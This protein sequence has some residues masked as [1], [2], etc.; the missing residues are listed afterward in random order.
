MGKSY[1]TKLTLRGVEDELRLRLEFAGPE[2]HAQMVSAVALAEH[3]GT[4]TVVQN[5]RNQTVGKVIRGTRLSTGVSFSEDKSASHH[6]LRYLFEMY[7]HHSADELHETVSSLV[8]RKANRSRSIALGRLVKPVAELIT[9]S[10]QPMP[11]TFGTARGIFG[12][13][14]DGLSHVLVL[15]IDK[16]PPLKHVDP[17]IENWPELAQAIARD[18]LPE[19]EFGDAHVGVYATSKFG[20]V[21]AN[22]ISARVVAWLKTALTLEQQAFW[23]EEVLRPKIRSNV[24]EWA[25]EAPFDITIYHPS[26]LIYTALPTIIVNDVEQPDPFPQRYIVFKG[27]GDGSVENDSVPLEKAQR[28]RSRTVRKKIEA[29]EASRMGV[30]QR[31]IA[32][33]SFETPSDGR[34]N[35]G[36]LIE[37]LIPGDTQR[38]LT[39]AIARAATTTPKH[40]TAERRNALREEIEIAL[41]RMPDDAING[42]QRRAEWVYPLEA[43]WERAEQKLKYCWVSQVASRA[44]RKR[45]SLEDGRALV[46]Q[47]IS[48][49]VDN[50]LAWQPDDTKVFAVAPHILINASLG[51]GKTEALARALKDI[52]LET[53][54]VHVLVP[55]DKLGAEVTRRI[56]RARHEREMRHEDRYIRQHRGR[57]QPGMC[58]NEAFGRHCEAMEEMGFSPYDEVCRQMCPDAKK[59]PWAQQHHDKGTGVIVRTHAHI[60]STY[61]RMG[62]DSD[63]KPDLFVVDE[64]P[65]GAVKTM[66]PDVPLADIK[67]TGRYAMQKYFYKTDGGKRASRISISGTADFAAHRN[68]LLAVLSKQD[69]VVR[70]ADFK[71][72]SNYVED[73]ESEYRFA[74]SLEHKLRT[75]INFELKTHMS[76]VREAGGRLTNEQ[77]ALVA[78]MQKQRRTSLAVTRLLMAA[79]ISLENGKL[80]RVAGVRIRDVKGDKVLS[81]VYSDGLP[82]VFRVTPTIFLD[83]TSHPLIASAMSGEWRQVETI[84]VHIE[85]GAYWYTYVGDQAHSRSSLIPSIPEHDPDDTEA[86]DDAAHKRKRADSRVSKLHRVILDRYMAEKGRGKSGTDV[87]VLCQKGVDRVLQEQGVPSR[88]SFLTYANTRGINDFEDVPCIIAIGRSCPPLDI[89]EQ[90]AE[91]VFVRDPSAGEIGLASSWIHADRD[92]ELATGDWARVRSEAHPDK[93]VEAYRFQVVDAEV[94]QGVGRGRGITRSRDNPLR[95]FLLGQTDIELPA[96]EVCCAIDLDRTAEETMLDRGILIENAELATVLYGEVLKGSVRAR[97]LQIANAWGTLSRLAASGDLRSPSGEKNRWVSMGLHVEGGAFTRIWIDT[98]RL[99]VYSFARLNEEIRAALGRRATVVDVPLELYPSRGLGDGDDYPEP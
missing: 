37:D 61:D 58:I 69:A 50:A 9:V 70:V 27:R 15:D 14:Q 84:D 83:A 46:A 38:P 56:Y 11:K 19:D 89:L 77:A 80:T 55:T 64:S 91:S 68:R 87:L 60:G 25:E 71:W 30:E 78:E 40:R 63:N 6:S 12:T 18:V 3:P 54:T 31:T 98:D 79:K 59:C 74:M 29:R 36:N 90:H 45:V 82:N 86:R 76:E 95:I 1:G 4:L 81:V 75:R 57:K 85:Q 67:P 66:L 65:L 35:G 23:V 97:S 24:S 5:P 41:S 20:L 73:F 2:T 17:T 43:K 42:E 8:N 99:G 62:E 32:R 51:A 94:I 26:R 21:G 96:H 49:A 33:I 34:A 39:Q 10:Q 53:R 44:G 7:G 92:V 47:H 52:D 93:H 13:M 72:L 22:R 16:M 88:V 48:R 28:H